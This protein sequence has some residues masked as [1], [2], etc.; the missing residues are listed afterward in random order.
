MEFLDQVNKD[1]FVIVNG[2]KVIYALY[3]INTHGH[4]LQI[5]DTPIVNGKL[6]DVRGKQG[7]A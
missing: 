3:D 1:S 7:M 2:S 4:N 6:V 5:D